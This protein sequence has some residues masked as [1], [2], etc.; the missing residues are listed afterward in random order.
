MEMTDSKRMALSLPALDLDTDS[1]S[2]V[3]Y[4]GCD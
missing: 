2:C 3:R 4:V 1:R